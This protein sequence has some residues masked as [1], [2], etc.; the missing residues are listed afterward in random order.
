M[1]WTLWRQF[2][3]YTHPSGAAWMGFPDTLTV[4]LKTSYLQTIFTMGYGCPT[5]ILY[6]D[7]FSLTMENQIIMEFFLF[8]N[9]LHKIPDDSVAKQVYATQKRLCLPGLVRICETL[10]SKLSIF[11]NLSEVSSSQWKKIVNRKITEKTVFICS[12]GLKVI[13][14]LITTQYQRKVT[15]LKTILLIW[16]LTK[17]VSIYPYV[18]ECDALYSK[19]SQMTRLMLQTCGPV[20]TVRLWIVWQTWGGAGAT[21]TWGRGWTCTPHWAWSLT[22]RP[23]SS[24]GRRRGHVWPHSG[25]LVFNTF[26]MGVNWFD[27]KFNCSLF[28]NMSVIYAK[29]FKIIII[30]IFSSFPMSEIFKC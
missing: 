16:Q 13:K 3:I 21:W 7:I 6:W 14:S 19:I 10:L 23:S 28:S 29:V 2:P 25:S 12:Y 15:K 1:I 22:S 18:Q 30:I 17:N 4:P 24:C 20:S 5:P 9:H 26:S 27:P 11:K 8:I